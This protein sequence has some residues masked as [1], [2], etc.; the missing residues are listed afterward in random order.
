MNVELTLTPRTS[1]LLFEFVQRPDFQDRFM[2][3]VF[4]YGHKQRGPL[5]LLYVSDGP[6][7]IRLERPDDL[8]SLVKNPNNA[9]RTPKEDIIR[10]GGNAGDVRLLAVPLAPSTWK[11]DIISHP[12]KQGGFFFTKLHLTDIEETE[13]FPLHDLADEPGI[14]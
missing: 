12:D 6:G 13:F 7:I 10:P 4:R 9:I 14:Y 11:L 3:E 2:Q 8:E 5:N 1:G